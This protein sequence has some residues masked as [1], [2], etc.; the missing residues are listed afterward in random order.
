MACSREWASGGIWARWRV[1]SAVVALTI[2][3]R[4]KRCPFPRQ[5]R[6][7]VVRPVLPGG[8]AARYG[9][10][11]DWWRASAFRWRALV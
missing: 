1:G 10:A 4:G 5:W 6:T 11:G 8:T 9:R 3:L 7:R 2:I